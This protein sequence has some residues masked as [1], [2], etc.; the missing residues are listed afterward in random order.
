M[1]SHSP[2]FIFRLQG[3]GSWLGWGGGSQPTLAAPLQVG[4]G[5]GSAPLAWVFSLA[6]GRE[7]GGEDDLAGF[8]WLVL[9][10]YFS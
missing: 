3:V 8:G 6:W 2:F 9:V 1:N 10:G 5:W 7:G 4:V